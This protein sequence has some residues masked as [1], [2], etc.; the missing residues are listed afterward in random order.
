MPDVAAAWTTRCADAPRYAV[1]AIRD[2]AA[3]G[4]SAP[5]YAAAPSAAARY[6]VDHHNRDN[7][8]AGLSDLTV[9]RPLF[10]GYRGGLQ[11][12]RSIRCTA[13]LLKLCHCRLTLAIAGRWGWLRRAEPAADV[14][15]V[16]M[17]RNRIIRIG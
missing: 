17:L 12:A 1:A 10:A 7:C 2:A 13:M 15:R 5:R 6:Y 16:E 11:W 8:Y 14:G 3:S 4:M 9:G